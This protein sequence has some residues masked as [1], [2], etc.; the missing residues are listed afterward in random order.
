MFTTFFSVTF[1][2][3]LTIRAVFAEITITTPSLAQVRPNSSGVCL[4][5][6]SYL[7]L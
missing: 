2:I 7:F 3:L 6:F 4:R 5:P 1:F